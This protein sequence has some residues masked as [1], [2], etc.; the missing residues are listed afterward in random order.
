MYMQLID[1]SGQYFGHSLKR[2]TKIIE[3]R[4]RRRREKRGILKIN[5][6]APNRDKQL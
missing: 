6:F 2:E 3:A 4:R 1:K 5:G